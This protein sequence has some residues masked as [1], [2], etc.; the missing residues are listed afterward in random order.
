MGSWKD[1]LLAC[2]EITQ[3]EYF[4]L[5]VEQRLFIINNKDIYYNV[6]GGVILNLSH[7]KYKNMSKM[8]RKN[9]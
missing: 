1:D 4:S 6:N 3:E 8:L 9:K 5:P 2:S 7:S